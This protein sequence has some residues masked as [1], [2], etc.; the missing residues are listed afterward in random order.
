MC[1]QQKKEGIEK[2]RRSAWARGEGE[3]MFINT[4]VIGV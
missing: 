3:W 2:P 4:F 1:Q